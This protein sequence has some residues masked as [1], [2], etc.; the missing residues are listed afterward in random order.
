MRISVHL[1]S[2]KDLLMPRLHIHQ[3]SITFQPMRVLVNSMDCLVKVA[4]AVGWDILVA[5]N[6]QFMNLMC[7]KQENGQMQGPE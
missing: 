5:L 1:V 7:E 6:N 2:T 4:P 3:P